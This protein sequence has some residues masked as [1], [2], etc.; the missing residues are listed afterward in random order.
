MLRLGRLGQAFE[1]G[2]RLTALAS[3]HESIGANQRAV[4]NGLLHQRGPLPASRRQRFGRL[5][6]AD[7]SQG[8]G[9]CRGGL[10]IF[11]QDLDEGWRAGRIPPRGDGIDDAY[12]R[13][14]LGLAERIAQG[15]LGLWSRNML[16]YIPGMDG[17]LLVKDQ[18]RHR[19]HRR[20]GCDEHQLPADERAGH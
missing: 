12:P 2:D 17:Q 5:G 3:G 8:L 19:R 13:A 10:G 16:E 6:R 18:G 20:G 14:P 1:Q 15:L 7:L 4:H 11:A 9:R